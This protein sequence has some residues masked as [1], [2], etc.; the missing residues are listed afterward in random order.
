MNS[1]KFGTCHVGKGPLCQ[2]KAFAD[3][4]EDYYKAIVTYN[5]MTRW[6]TFQDNPECVKTI[7]N[8]EY[9]SAVD[10]LNKGSD[11]DEDKFGL[12]LFLGVAIGAV[13]VIAILLLVIYMKKGKTD[14]EDTEGLKVT[15]NA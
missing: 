8:A 1:L 10:A 15:T 3:M 13:V 11:E 7:L 4:S 6:A 2:P 14:D 12:Y 9:W 5:N